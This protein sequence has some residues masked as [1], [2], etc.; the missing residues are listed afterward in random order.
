MGHANPDKWQTHLKNKVLKVFKVFVM[1]WQKYVVSNT[2]SA[3]IKGKEI[4][5]TFQI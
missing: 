2:T 4:F 3:G 5:F 1:L